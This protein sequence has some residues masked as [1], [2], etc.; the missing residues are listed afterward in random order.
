MVKLKIDRDKCK[1]C[2][3]CV[4]FCPKG[5]LSAEEKLNKRGVKPVKFKEDA[6]CIG[7]RMCMIICPDNCIEIDT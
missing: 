6:G 4:S 5:A 2:M 7:C 3:L 1:G